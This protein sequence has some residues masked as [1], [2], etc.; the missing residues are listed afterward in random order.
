MSMKRSIIKAVAACGVIGILAAGG[1]VAYLTDYDSAVNEFT[2]G[3]VDIELEEPSWTPDENT[4]IEPSQVI[5]KDPKITN[6]GV[7]DAFVYLEVSIPIANVMIADASGNRLEKKDR[8]LFEFTP[9]E[10]WTR[11]SMTT[12]GSN[13]VYTFAYNKV[14]KAGQTTSPLFNHVVFINIV[15]GQLDTRQFQIPVR[16]YAIQTENTGGDQ[17]SVVEQA[18]R[19]YEKYVNQNSGQDGQVSR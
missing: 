8:E 17:G 16:A 18:T 7:N 12:V 10:E 19:A 1:T 15:E 9:S 2:V 4:K 11:L 3:K 6:R 5:P 14:L 13:R